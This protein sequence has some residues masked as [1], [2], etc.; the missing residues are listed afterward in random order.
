MPIAKE[1]SLAAHVKHMSK[2]KGRERNSSQPGT[3]L[4]GG[5]PYVTSEQE[6]DNIEP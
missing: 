5:S 1:A 3:N 6:D 4:Y 2:S